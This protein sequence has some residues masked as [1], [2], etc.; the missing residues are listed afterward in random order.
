MDTSREAHNK[1]VETVSTLPVNT[2]FEDV[3]P[4]VTKHYAKVNN[5]PL[6]TGKSCKTCGGN[7]RINTDSDQWSSKG[8]H[9]GECYCCY[10]TRAAVRKKDVREFLE[11]YPAEKSLHS[12]LVKLKMSLEKQ[13][14][15][16]MHIHHAIPRS[17]KDKYPNPEMNESV[18]NKIV[19]TVAE[20]KAIH[21][22]I[23]DGT[24]PWD[25]INTVVNNIPTRMV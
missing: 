20:H 2:I 17:M 22:K 13:L 11:E 6:Y 3:E 19:V 12:D 15:V 4:I 23:R 1:D 7:E 16:Q 14:G 18:M 21:D 5:R 10:N 24:H 25:A 8:K 9:D